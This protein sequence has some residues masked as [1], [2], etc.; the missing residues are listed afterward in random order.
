[1]PLSIRGT[2]LSASTAGVAIAIMLASSSI[3]GRAL[4]QVVQLPATQTF[5]YS[6][7]VT[8][9]DSGQAYLGGV[10]RQRSGSASAGVGPSTSRAIGNA[11]GGTSVVVSAS[12]IDLQA[13]DA[14]I[15]NASADKHVSNYATR[16]AGSTIINTLTPSLYAR[17][18]GAD[19]LPPPDD[20]NAWQMALG[21][22]S[23][24]PVGPSHTVARDNTDVRYFMQRAKQA[25]DVGRHSAAL[26]YYR[27]A[28][29]RLTPS[30]LARLQ[31]FQANATTAAQNAQATAME[32]EA[33]AAG[34]TPAGSE[35]ASP[36]VDGDMGT[37]QPAVDENL[38]PFG[39]P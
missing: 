39:A 15:A 28:Y 23:A 17:R 35:P 24:S 8:V 32:A 29:E 19:Q 38:D 14:A 2:V 30:Q 21:G 27:L 31:E 1:M 22:G 12:I 37:V 5:G 9:P 25:A 16:N 20:P 3:G 34:T 11:S 7:S 4:A 6:G 26:V 33:V 18:L 10:A 13:M 36:I